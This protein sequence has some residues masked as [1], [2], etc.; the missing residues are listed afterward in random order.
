MRLKALINMAAG[1]AFC[2]F[3]GGCGLVDDPDLPGCGEKSEGLELHFKVSSALGTVNPKATRA[4]DNAHEEESSEIPQIEDVVNLNDLA[5]FIFAGTGD[6]A[7][8]VCA[9]TDIAS[10]NH[11]NMTVAGGAGV[12]DF[13]VMVNREALE[14]YLGH[15]LSP[16]GTQAVFFRIV[17]LAN[18]NASRTAASG[19]FSSLPMQ[20]LSATNDTATTFGEFMTAADQLTYMM[21]D[22]WYNPT[23]S[24]LA[25][26][27][28]GLIPMFGTLSFHVTEEVIYESRPER[29]IYVGEINLLRAVAKVRIVDAMPR[30]DGDYPC[31]TGAR[32]V[33]T[34]TVGSVLPAN[35]SAYENG[36]QVHATNIPDQT[37][38]RTETV[39]ISNPAGYRDPDVATPTTLPEWFI[40][41]PEQTIEN[42]TVP[43]LII[44]V[45]PSANENEMSFTVPMSGYK[46][47]GF[48]W[49]GSEGVLLRNHIYT[50]TVNNADLTYADLTFNVNPWE[51]S[52][53]VLDYEANPSVGD[54]I[55]WTAGT[56]NTIQTNEVFLRPWDSAANRVAAECSFTIDT[57]RNQTWTA[58]L[59]SAEGNP[60]AFM[61][62]DAD[63]NEVETVTGNV[64]E[65]A[66]LKIVSTNPEPTIKSSAMLQV[67][68][69]MGYGYMEAPVA[70]NFGN[71]IISQ[72]AQ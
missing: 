22:S 65:K 61:F 62:L 59:I 15:E 50:V 30:R 68:V 36:N 47:V 53:L 66:T 57:P 7:P 69:N 6:N 21:T 26:K 60:G 49:T 56:Y 3:S 64:G 13:R 40:Y 54:A 32:F 10:G 4:D 71:Y 51:Q 25:A 37:A 29:R 31:V 67:I 35:A 43:A 24:S 72:A 41:S 16:N 52:R 18:T 14:K 45:K 20:A 11:P 9:C 42:G 63:G 5:F 44:S 70:G 17:L 12:Y 2:L 55:T 8:M 27:V 28:N 48:P 23:A 38:A 39:F 33:Y 58:F 34:S 46:G 19:N 1:A